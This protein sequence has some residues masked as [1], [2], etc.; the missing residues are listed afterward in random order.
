MT[1]FT[2]GNFLKAREEF[3]LGLSTATGC[4]S[5]VHCYPSMSLSYLAWTLFVLGQEVEAKECA[6]R[7]VESAR[8]ESSHAMATALS[9]CSYVYQ[10]MGAIEKVYELTGELVEHTKKHGEQMYLRR[11][12][13]IRC[14]ADCIRHQNE[15]PIRE[16]N[17]NI[18]FLLQSKEEIETT[19]LLGVMAEMQ[20]KFGRLLDAQTSLNRALEIADR[21]EERFYLAELYRLKET[22]AQIDPRRFSPMQG[23]DYMAMARKTAEKQH[24]SSWLHRL[25]G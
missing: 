17:S 3:E 9:N 15:E 2:L 11:G 13:I 25:S 19:F 14:W 18:D 21:N 8:R 12:M 7:A 6:L 16:M 23:Q 5:T 1:E 24:A 22:L 20:I 10:C 4:I